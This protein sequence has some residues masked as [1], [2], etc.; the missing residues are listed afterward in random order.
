HLDGYMNSRLMDLMIRRPCPLNI[1]WVGHGGNIGLDFFDYIINDPFTADPQEYDFELEKEIRIPSAFATSGVFEFDE[2]LTKA[3]FGFADHT[4]LIN[5][6]NNHIKINKPY[7]DAAARV[8]KA[9][10]N[11][12]LWFNESRR[13]NSVWAISNYL[14]SIGID[15]SQYFFAGRLEPKAKHYARLYVSDFA[16]DT[17][18]VSMASG[19][20]DN[21]WAELPVISMPGDKFTNRTA[22]SFNRTLGLDYLNTNSVDEYVDLAIELATNPEKLARLKAHMR[23]Y[24]RQTS[25][26]DGAKFA[27]EVAAGISAAVARSREG[28]PPANIDVP[29]IFDPI[30]KFS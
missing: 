9:V 24:K 30:P 28:L 2:S 27:K 25:M 4:I 1:Y 23:T 26:F 5:A 3:D 29:P 6:F 22:G 19:A 17:F 15:D 11:A 8:L 21:I 16:L 10:P 20:L 18:T 13:V 12:V 7:L 14:R